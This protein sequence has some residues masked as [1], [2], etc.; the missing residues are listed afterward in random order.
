MKQGGVELWLQNIQIK[1]LKVDVIEKQA[2][3]GNIFS[4]A[5]A[6]KTQASFGIV[7]EF[8]MELKSELKLEL[9]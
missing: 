4:Q 8:L 5:M 9:K 6:R 1:C 3:K 2:S 7:K